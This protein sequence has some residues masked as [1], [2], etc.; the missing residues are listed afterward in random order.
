MAI[1]ND[2]A[3]GLKKVDKDLDFMMSCFV[4]VLEQLDHKDLAGTLPWMGKRKLRGVQIFSYRGVQAYSIAFQLLNMVEE[5]ASAQSKRLREDKHG[6][7]SDPGSWGRALRALVDAGLTDKQIAKRLNRM[8]VEPVLTAHPTE[9]KRATVLEIHRE[10][11]KLLVRRENNMWT[12][13]EQRAIREEIKVAL[14]RLWRTGEIY[15]QKPDVQSEL[16][17]INYFLSKV[18]PDAVVSMDLRL[19]QA[20]EE[21]GLDP[22]R[23]EHPDSL[24]QIV[25]GTWVG[26]DRDGHPLVTAEVTARA[27]NLFRSTAIAICNERLETLGQRLSLGDHLQS[28]PPVFIRQVEKH[29]AAHG[30]A[31][32]AA[33]KRNIGETWRQYVNLVRLR[34]PNTVGELGPGQ[35]RTPEGVIADLLFLRETLIEVGAGRIARAELDPLLRFLRTFGFHMAVLDI[36]QNSAFHDKAIG[37]LLAAT[38]QDDA[39][40][41]QWDESRRLGFLDSELRS[42]RPFLRE[43]ASI[44][45]EADA[46]VACHRTLVGHIEQYGAAG[47]GSLIVSMTRSVSDLLSVYLLAREAGLTAGGSDDAYCLLP[48]VPLFETIGDLERSTGIMDAFLSHPMTQRTLKARRDAGLTDGLTQQVMIGYSDSNK[49]GGILASLWN[50]YR[51]QQN[52]AAVGEKHGVRIVFFHGRGGTISRGAGPTHR[53]IDALPQGS[54][55]GEMRVTEQGES[56][57]QK[58]ANHITA[59]NNLELL[60]AG[61]TQNTLLHDVAVRSE[62]AQAKVMDRLAEFSR[63][64]YQDLIRTPRFIEFF[65]Q[66][67][68]IDVIEASRIGSRPSRRTGAASLEDL[69]A[70]PWVF[71]W[72]QARFYLSGWYGVGSALARLK[73]EDPKGF[74]VIRKNYDDWPPLRYMLKNA[75]TSVLASNRSMMKLYGGLVTDKKLRSLFLNRILAEHNLAR[76]MLDE[77]SG[78]KLS[79]GRPRL[80]KVIALRE[81]AIDLLHEQQVALLK[82]WRKKVADGDRKEADALL[83]QMLLSLN[84]IAAGLQA[85]G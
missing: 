62:A 70:I 32:E 81:S 50:L 46:V 65:R 41:A 33:L 72:S 77:L 39:N 28:P 54:I 31:G 35:H 60:T 82:D 5:N 40:F 48:V 83:P 12:V 23:V 15:H 29:A 21:A 49:D 85:T 73:E 24:P 67:T 69:R 18:F 53:F 9:A 58:Y 56:I 61:V 47:L 79:E 27:L 66:A 76:K 68:P 74:E 64:A 26:G 43:Q 1:S 13:A 75:S 10:I 45:P 7:A 52:L 6:L 78:S 3:R 25:L 4:E 34:L 8:R 63:E 20:W 22:S 59:V 17:N 2:L 11:Y 30:E 42:T 37:Q 38:G 80:R 57:T 16:R 19:R 55:Q 51:A 44:G 36:R 71:A 14:E 84:A